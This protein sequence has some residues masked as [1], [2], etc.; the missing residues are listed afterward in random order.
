MDWI[1]VDK[2][3]PPAGRLVLVAFLNPLDKKR[4]SIAYWCPA[5]HMEAYELSDAIELDYD[6]K[7]DTYWEP[8][9]WYE[10]T[11]ACTDYSAYFMTDKP[12]LWAEIPWPAL[13][14]TEQPPTP[15]ALAG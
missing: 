8:E 12:L 15:S 10:N 1:D 6:E 2:K 7:T 3:M 4:V 5:R 14:A 9:G 13:E 11:N